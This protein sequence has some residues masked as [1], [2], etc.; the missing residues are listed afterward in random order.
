[1]K[2]GFCFLL[3]LGLVSLGCNNNKSTSDSSSGQPA[4]ASPTSTAN[5]GSQPGN[6]PS[7]EA[8]NSS[9]APV[10]DKQFIADVAK[11]NR[12]EVELGRM[13][14]AKAQ[15][16]DVKHFAQMMVKDHTK[17]LNELEKLAHS[18]NVTLPNDLPDDA[19]SLEGKLANETGKQLEKDYMDS[20]V[21]D[22]QKDVKEFQEASQNV[23]DPDVKEW[24]GKT[25]PTLQK[26][27]EIAQQVDSKLNGGNSAGSNPGAQ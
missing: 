26:H 13:V 18:K 14:A 9:T 23:Q 27:L 21:Q 20:M 8:A 19:K 12:A 17:A 22:H 7:S 15:D 1:M 11:G 24:A 3:A 2:R 6:A 5:S 16:P 4:N 25:L 10:S